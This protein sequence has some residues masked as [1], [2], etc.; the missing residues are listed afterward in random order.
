MT[1]GGTLSVPTSGVAP[2]GVGDWCLAVGIPSTDGTTSSY[3]LLRVLGRSSALVRQSSGARVEPQALAANIDTVMILV[4][5]D[6][7]ISQR[8]VERF[9]TVAWESGAA[10]VLVL[11][12]VDLVDDGA[13]AAAWSR[14]KR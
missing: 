3:E 7:R 1:A 2:V 6:R 8:Q 9:V 11:T 12:K 5:L 10:P 14:S 13:A 4:P